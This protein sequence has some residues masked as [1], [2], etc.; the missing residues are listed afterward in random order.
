LATYK[1]RRLAKLSAARRAI[2]KETGEKNAKKK[3]TDKKQRQRVYIFATTY[4]IYCILYIDMV[5]NNTYYR[6]DKTLTS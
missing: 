2:K 1:A 6:K 3:K 4:T 5:Y